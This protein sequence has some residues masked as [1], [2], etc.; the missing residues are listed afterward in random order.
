MALCSSGENKFD[1][2]GVEFVIPS[3]YKR[4]LYLGIFD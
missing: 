4:A 2:Q 3:E 1:G